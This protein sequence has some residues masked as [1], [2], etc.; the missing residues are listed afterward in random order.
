MINQLILLLF[1]ILTVCSVVIGIM[2]AIYRIEQCI[3]SNNILSHTLTACIT[4]AYVESERTRWRSFC[5]K[6]AY[7]SAL[8]WLTQL[9]AKRFTTSAPS[10]CACI[11]VSVIIVSTVLYG[12]SGV[13]NNYSI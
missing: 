7:S 2:L 8:Y 4:R 3:N 13:Q 12:G 9:N 6:A 11:N 1:I 10:A 5:Q